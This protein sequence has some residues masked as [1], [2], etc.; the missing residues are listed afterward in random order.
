[1]QKPWHNYVTTMAKSSGAN[2]LLKQHNLILFN[3]LYK[4]FEENN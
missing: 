3:M 1:M 4:T 2:S